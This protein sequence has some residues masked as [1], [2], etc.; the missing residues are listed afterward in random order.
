MCLTDEKK[1]IYYLGLSQKVLSLLTKAEDQKIAQEI[2][3]KCWSWLQNQSGSGEEFYYL[4][5]NEDNGITIIEEMS[6]VE[7]DKFIWNCVIDAVAYTSRKAFENE[8]AV[9]FP[10][11]IALVD[12][13][14][15]AHFDDCYIRCNNGDS[16]DISKILVLLA[17]SD[18]SRNNAR[19]LIA[20]L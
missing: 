17:G 3:D 16:G 18:I 20:N 4:L 11:P 19:D 10:E 2:L 9:Y 8:G 1:L 13:D 15:A 14:L 6:T 7:M 5:D 12:D